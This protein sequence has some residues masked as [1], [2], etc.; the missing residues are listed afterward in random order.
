M[1]THALGRASA[2]DRAWIAAFLAKPR[3]RRLPRE[4]MRL[5][6]IIARSGSLNWAQSAA[7]TF[8]Q[9][10]LREFDKSAFAGASK[11]PDLDWLRACV[12]YLVR[13]DV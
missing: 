3:Q 4:V 11:G 10:A 7:D 5:H 2:A 1:L 12:D 6:D 8:A 9:A 13:R